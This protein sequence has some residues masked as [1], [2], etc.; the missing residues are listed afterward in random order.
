MK[1][2]VVIGMGHF[3]ASIA[4]TLFS[5]GHD[6]LAIDINE[7]KV[8]EVTDRVTHTVQADSTNENA[9]LALGIRNFD[10][11]VVS[12][13]QDMQ[14]NILTTLIL[15]EMGVKYVVAKARTE[16][17]GKVLYRIG[18]DQVIFPERDM[19]VRVAHN[20]VAANILDYIELSPDFSIVEI[21]APGNFVGRSL[22]DLDLRARYSVNV[23]AIKSGEE[24]NLT[25]KAEDVIKKEDILIVA[26]E[27]KKLKRLENI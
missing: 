20:L 17:H 8:Q 9:L 13:G 25:P 16:L 18:A 6:V 22:L 2:F 1:Q 14:S 3:G 24:L 23:I 21:V 10:V 27:N 7:E 12:I 26:G 15:K 5:M 19:G 11:A 4:T